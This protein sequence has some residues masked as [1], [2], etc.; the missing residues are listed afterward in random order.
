VQRTLSGALGTAAEQRLHRRVAEALEELCGEDPGPRVVELAHHWLEG[1]RAS[2][3]PKAVGYARRAGD[4][5]LEQ[6]APDEAMRWYRRALNALSGAYA[7]DDRTR[8]EL[9]V[10]L[11]DALNQSGDPSFRATLLGAAMLAQE[12]GDAGLL[13]RAALANTRGFVSAS[14]TVDEE[15]IEV[16]EAALEAVGPH[17]STDRARLLALLASELTF[18]G[19][20][21]RRV[22]LSGEA[23]A[24]A[25][26]L[27]DPATL[28]AVLTQRFTT[29]WTP[30][31]LDERM[32]ETAEAVEA[33]DRLGHPLAQFR[34]VHWRGTARVEAGDL[35]GAR[36]DVARETEL[37]LRL[38]Q[39]TALWMATYDRANLALISGRLDE[40]ERLAG[41]ALAIATGSS[42]PDG[43]FFYA[44]QLMNVRFEQG[45]IG[46]LRAPLAETVTRAQGIPAFRAA[47]ALACCEADIPHAR[48]LLAE[49][50]ANGFADL[51]YDL[52]W[53]AGLSLYAMV[54]RA[55]R[56]PAAA[57]PLY[58]LLTPSARQVV[59]TGVSAWMSTEHHLGVLAALLGRTS[60][61]RAHLAAAATTHKRIG[62]PVWLA[63]TRF[64]Q[65]LLLLDGDEPRAVP[66]A[67]ALLEQARDAAARHGAA[68]VEREAAEALARVT[69]E[70]VT[71]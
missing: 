52:T 30:E 50:A 70:P 49:G 11:G 55:L 51:P 24:M 64:E 44:S 6:L 61:A 63:R 57:E 45:R 53:P 8:G 26:R 9:L 17:D 29:I 22:T 69:R 38:G 33:A 5:A 37:A 65:A 23:L 16:L 14:G 21:T 3:A 60:D 19:D 58:V 28:S 13:I 7:A 42:Q 62:A 39:P 25:R 10:C 34:A 15:R 18:S 67:I 56:D 2:D 41:E 54:A 4:H 46:E 31:S 40:A 20:W 48:R 43:L 66:E 59:F 32:D 71:R 12:L 47:L 68:G 35:A 1:G 27:H 36:A